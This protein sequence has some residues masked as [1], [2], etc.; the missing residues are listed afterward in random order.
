MLKRQK[1]KT[2]KIVSFLVSYGGCGSKTEKI[3]VA[4]KQS[5][6]LFLSNS[7]LLTVA[8]FGATCRKFEFSQFIMIKN[9]H[10]K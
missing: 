8:E 7:K 6:G 3:A 9:R 5:T 4:M 10:H 1:N 2:L